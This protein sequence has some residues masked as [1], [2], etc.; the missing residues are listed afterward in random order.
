MLLRRVLS[1]FSAR[2]MSSILSP[3]AGWPL[4]RSGPPRTSAPSTQS[5]IRRLTITHERDVTDSELTIVPRV[6]FY[7][8]WGCILPGPGGGKSHSTATRGMR[9]SLAEPDSPTASLRPWP[10]SAPSQPR[11]AGPGVCRVCVVII[12]DNA[13]PESRLP[14][15]TRSLKYERRGL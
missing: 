4:P 9:I 13:S 7:A 6:Y 10:R 2:A 11:D 1:S 8:H 3:G 15:N 14:R 5:V 12:V